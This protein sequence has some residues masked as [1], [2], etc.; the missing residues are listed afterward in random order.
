MS[1]TNTDERL[2]PRM[3]EALRLLRAAYPE[4]RISIIGAGAL[5]FHLDMKWRRT[6]DIDVVITIA[7]EDLATAAQKLVGWTRQAPPRWVAPNGV[8]VDI[9]PAP[10]AALPLREVSWPDG[11]KMS[12][13]GIQLALTDRSHVV[14]AELDITVAPVPIVAILKMAAYLDRPWVRTKDLIDLAHILDEYPPSDDDR[15]FE[16][17]I[18]EAG[19]TEDQA[20][21][22]ILAREI[23]ALVEPAD[24][25][26]VKAFLVKMADDS[27]HW[28]RFVTSS[29]LRDEDRLRAR[30][31]AFRD[32]FL[33]GGAPKSEP[34]AAPQV[35]AIALKFIVNGE[36]VL[37]ELATDDPLSTAVAAALEKSRNT[38]RPAAEW[39]LR[40]DNGVV[41]PD[42]GQTPT[43]LGL[44]SGTLL[45][46]SLRAGA[47][48]HAAGA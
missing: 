43:Q 5:A 29:P 45:Y 28:S 33:A 14:S 37:I 4:E 34:L 40:R 39:E 31:D 9:V 24:R 46:L 2:E 36:E 11:S 15:F 38:G 3:L 42:Q 27:E 47:G 48:G 6:S 12:L 21:G 1:A 44:A 10:A 35:G 41:I 19:L 23:S 25:E 16:D 22:T 8:K 20:R 26:V 17:D 18:L 32:T 13:A 7:V 30:F